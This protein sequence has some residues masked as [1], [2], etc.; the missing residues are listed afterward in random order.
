MRRPS[1]G[2]AERRTHDY[3]RNGTTNLYAALDVASG[4]VIAEMSPRHRAEEFRRFLSVVEKAVPAHINGNI[5][6]VR[7]SSPRSAPGSPAGTKTQNHTS[8]TRPQTRSS[9]ASPPTASE[10]TTQ[11]TSPNAAVPSKLAAR[12]GGGSAR[13]SEVRDS[14]FGSRREAKNQLN[15]SPRNADSSRSRLGG[16]SNG[17]RQLRILR[18]SAP[19]ESG[20][21]LLKCVY[22]GC[23]PLSRPAA[24]GHEATRAALAALAGRAS[25]RMMGT[26]AALVGLA[27]AEQ[28]G[29][30]QELGG[31]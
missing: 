26:W 24:A 16:L 3:V 20:S 30:D 2:V 11:D 12:G 31:S 22:A 18:P 15:A 4:Q 1:P 21:N 28:V 29:R 7:F 25:L 10:S 17:L 14:K 8:G 27:R 9:T 23:R 5:G 13:C 19:P 6:A